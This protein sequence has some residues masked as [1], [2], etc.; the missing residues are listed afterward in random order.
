MMILSQSIWWFSRE[1]IYLYQTWRFERNVQKFPHDTRLLLELD[2]SV[3]NESE[4]VIN[5]IKKKMMKI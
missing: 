5:E 2:G 3:E 4:N 1:E